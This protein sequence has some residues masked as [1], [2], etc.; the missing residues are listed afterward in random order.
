MNAYRAALL[1]V[2]L[3][4][5]PSLCAGDDLATLEAALKTRAALGSELTARVASLYWQTFK[6]VKTTGPTTLEEAEAKMA[7]APEQWG[8][9]MAKTAYV[10]VSHG[11]SVTQYWNTSRPPN[12]NFTDQV[13][14][15]WQDG[16]HSE[17]ALFDSFMGARVLVGEPLDPTTGY[18]GVLGLGR[19][20][21]TLLDSLKPPLEAEQGVMLRG[22]ACLRVTGADGQLW[23][24]PDLGYAPLR[25]THWSPAERLIGGQPGKTE[26]IPG[27]IRLE[28]TDWWGYHQAGQ[29]Q[30]SRF[31]LFRAFQETEHER[32]ILTLSLDRI[33]KAAV[34]PEEAAKLA[35]PAL[36]VPTLVGSTVQHGRSLPGL[37]SEQFG[38]SARDVWTIGEGDGERWGI[39]IK[40]LTEDVMLKLPVD[41]FFE[42]K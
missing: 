32:H 19:G 29:A 35:G 25:Q 37:T 12:G 5:V 7:A 11:E 24:A 23:L 34:G 30:V 39:S 6:Q 2:V 3:L 31:R 22:H 27:T 18:E 13:L 10:R 20:E 17:E 42:G 14:Y 15:R 16:T 36:H 4:A 28:V 41:P 1:A 8:F 26:A 38:L 21:G 33:E 9:Q 40:Q